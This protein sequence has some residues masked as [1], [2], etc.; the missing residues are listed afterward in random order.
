M[1]T[2]D[3]KRLGIHSTQKV[4]KIL[5]V[6][7]GLGE[8]VAQRRE[9]LGAYTKNVLRDSAA[10]AGIDFSTNMNKPDLI[11]HL[12]GTATNEQFENLVNTAQAETLSGE[13]QTEDETEG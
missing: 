13:E 2:E 9:T 8:E 1:L 4:G 5:A 6:T 7:K 12:A 10:A 11:A 3:A